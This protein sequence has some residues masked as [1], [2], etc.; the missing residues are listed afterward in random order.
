[1]SEGCGKVY[2]DKLKGFIPGTIH[3]CGEEGNLCNDCREPQ[4]KP[5]TLRE[6][7]KE[8]FIIIEK[9]VG[10]TFAKKIIEL[11]EE[12]DK[13]AVD[14]LIEEFCEKK[15]GEEY[16]TKECSC[17]KCDIIKNIFGEFEK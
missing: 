14:D 7:R 11:V 12:Q 10:E 8:L 4:E 2:A 1:M 5:T 13:K 6:K 3:F 15:Y 9:V 17:E 16:C